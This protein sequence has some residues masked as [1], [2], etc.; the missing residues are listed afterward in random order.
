MIDVLCTNQIALPH[1][2]LLL[3]ISVPPHFIPLISPSTPRQP[4]GYR[5]EQFERQIMEIKHITLHY[6]SDHCFFTTTVDPALSAAFGNFENIDIDSPK[7][8]D[9]LRD[10]STKGETFLQAVNV[11]SLVSIALIANKTVP[12][13]T[14]TEDMSY[15]MPEYEQSPSSSLNINWLF[16]SYQCLYGADFT[17]ISHGYVNVTYSSAKQCFPLPV[18]KFEDIINNNSQW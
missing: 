12:N 13:N 14:L 7:A 18:Q 1:S 9:Y 8:I 2:L 5:A 4:V 15:A 16:A 3:F 17:G 10:V 11:R 6:F